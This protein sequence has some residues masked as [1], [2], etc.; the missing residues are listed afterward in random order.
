MDLSVSSDEDIDN[1]S[2]IE[3][4]ENL[5]REQPKEIIDLTID[6]QGDSSIGDSSPQTSDK[7]SHPSKKIVSSCRNRRTWPDPTIVRDIASLVGSA[8]FYSAYI[9]YLEL[10]IS[11]LRDLMSQDYDAPIL[12]EMWTDA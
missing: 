3:V 10:R 1:A 8:Q 11:C 9:P 2:D 12:P 4:V 7:E 5:Q 6:E